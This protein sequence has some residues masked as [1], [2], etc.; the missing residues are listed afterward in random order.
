MLESENQWCDREAIF[1]RLT[2]G[3]KSRRQELE[4]SLQ[5]ENIPQ[6]K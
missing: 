5:E 1:E 2:I 4:F 3:T 6:S